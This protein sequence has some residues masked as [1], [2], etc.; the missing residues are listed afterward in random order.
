LWMGYELSTKAPA[1]L[2]RLVRRDRKEQ[3]DFLGRLA[4]KYGYSPPAYEVETRFS[5]NTFFM[6]F[7][8]CPI[9]DYFRD[10]GEEDL[11][12]FRKTWCKM[13]W[14]IIEVM[15]RGPVRYERTQTLSDGDPV[16]DMRWIVEDDG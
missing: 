5:G 6:D 10:Q 9:H 16:C 13:D 15:V 2:A 4:T 1:A 14:A 3:M 8:R 11:E 7:T 12:F